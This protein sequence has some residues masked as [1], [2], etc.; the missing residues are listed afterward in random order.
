ML[1]GNQQMQQQ[2]QQGAVP[3]QMSQGQAINQLGGRPTQG[4]M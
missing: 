1:G 2:M 4:G 3:G